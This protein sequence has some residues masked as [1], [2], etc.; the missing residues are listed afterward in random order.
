MQL[1]E[2]V[3]LFSFPCFFP[4]KLCNFFK[5][6]LG[7]FMLVFIGGLHCL[8]NVI[9]GIMLWDIVQLLIELQFKNYPMKVKT[10]LQNHKLHLV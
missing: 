9:L 5:P 6:M 4:S 10:S 3:R 8:L 2:N 1:S 7:H